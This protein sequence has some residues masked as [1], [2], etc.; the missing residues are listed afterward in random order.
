MIMNHIGKTLYVF[1]IYFLSRCS[2]YETER[3]KL[4]SQVHHKNNYFILLSD[5]DKAR[6][7]LLQEDRDIL[8][9][10]CTY[11]HSCFAKGPVQAKILLLR[12]QR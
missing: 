4:Y 1:S 8:F 3:A 11:I 10:L 6:W 12:P 9:G 7:L 5:N 2:L